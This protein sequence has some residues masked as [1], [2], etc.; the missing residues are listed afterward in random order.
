MSLPQ[1]AQALGF[2]EVVPP[3]AILSDANPS[4]R[5]GD[6]LVALDADRTRADPQTPT[7]LTIEQ[8]RHH[9]LWQLPFIVAQ[10]AT[11]NLWQPRQRPCTARLPAGAVW[12]P[13]LCSFQGS[14]EGSGTR[15]TPVP[16][17]PKPGCHLCSRSDNSDRVHVLLIESRSTAQPY[18]AVRP[19]GD[20]PPCAYVIRGGNEA[21]TNL[22]DGDVVEARPAAGAVGL[23]RS[24]H[25]CLLLGLLLQQKP[26]VAVIGIFLYG[27]G[28][29]AASDEEDDSPGSP[30]SRS[31]RCS[32]ESAS[33]TRF[34]RPRTVRVGLFHQHGTLS[35]RPRPT[36]IGASQFFGLQLLCPVTGPMPPLKVPTVIT[37]TDMFAFFQQGMP[38]W[39]SS[40]V[41][42]WPAVV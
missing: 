24:L 25:T 11:V 31:P 40:L 3:H 13:D 32:S 28:S 36:T 33:A 5:H 14:W 8:A 22:R 17:I 37:D 1:V 30:R 12:R 29:V 16:W 15:W 39:D 19:Q 18:C 4:L 42:V 35:F 26:S 34:V 10:E 20:I 6:V 21:C 2:S 41:P 27:L 7:F 9:A 23:P 38:R